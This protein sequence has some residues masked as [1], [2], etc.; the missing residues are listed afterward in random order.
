MGVEPHGARPA[1][2]LIWPD[3]DNSD[4]PAARFGRCQVIEPDA[5]VHL[6][7]SETPG[8]RTEH[9][10][11]W[12][13]A[14]V[15]ALTSRLGD[16]SVADHLAANRRGGPAFRPFG[17]EEG[18]DAVLRMALAATGTDPLI[19]PGRPRDARLI[20]GVRADGSVGGPPATGPAALEAVLIAGGDRFALKILE[21]ST[22]GLLQTGALVLDLASVDTAPMAAML[23]LR[24]LDGFAR[25]PRLL[26]IEPNAVPVIQRRKIADRFTSDG[27]PDQGFDLETPGLEFEPGSDPVQVELDRPGGL[28]IWTRTERLADCG[29]GDRRFALDPA[30]ARI[31]FGNGVNGAVPPADTPIYATYQVTEGKAGNLAANRKWVVPGFAGLF[32]VN[33]DPTVGGEEA[34]GWLEQR[35][36]ARRLFRESHGLVSGADFEAAAQALVGLEVGRARM[37]PVS[38]ADTATG[39]MRLVVMRARGGVERRTVPETPRWIEAV[40]AQ[41]APRV[42]LGSNL[43]VI[44]PTYI[45]FSI[46]ARIMA[47]PKKDPAEVEK[48]I[49]AELGKRLTLVGPGQRPFGLPLTPLD[50]IA[51]IQALPDVRRVD[52]LAIVPADGGTVSKPPPNGLPRLDLARCDIDVSRGGAP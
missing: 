45:G 23:E 25:A 21:D 31:S 6:D 33:P 35:R 15:E 49:L 5:A 40:R 28:E 37:M 10:Q 30:A 34:S 11:L 20:L 22:Q 8:F 12:I 24:A 29:P 17:E 51:W 41:L 7:K 9:R 3:H 14:R 4:G 1:R 50:L 19:E 16:G 42:P 13:P 2:G 47:E 43:R 36:E 26:R 48:S 44:A 27:S 18:E 32:G 39:T 46:R 38:V 52:S